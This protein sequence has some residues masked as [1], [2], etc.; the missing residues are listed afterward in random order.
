MCRERSEDLSAGRRSAVAGVS[1]PSVRMSTVEVR[2]SPA[3]STTSVSYVRLQAGLVRENVSLPDNAEISTNSAPPPGDHALL[4]FVR[5]AA[6][7]FL[8]RRVGTALLHRVLFG[9]SRQR[10]SVVDLW[11]QHCDA[12]DHRCERS[13]TP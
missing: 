11:K 10:R 4:S 12:S 8:A 2:L 6:D 3:S 13:A 7:Y 1:W 5:D 9:E